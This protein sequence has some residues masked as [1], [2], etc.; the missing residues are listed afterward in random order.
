M[1]RL[2]LNLPAG[3][4]ADNPRIGRQ[5]LMVSGCAVMTL[6]CLGSHATESVEVLL[7]TRLA[8]G[9]G[10]ALAVAGTSAYI[11]D[12]SYTIPAYRARLMGVQTTMVNLGWVVGPPAAG[13]FAAAHGPSVGFLLVSASAATCTVLLATVPPMPPAKPSAAAAGA[14]APS[15]GNGSTAAMYSL[16]RDRQQQGV[17]ALTVGIWVGISAELSVVL[18]HASNAWEMSPAEIGLLLAC[19]S[20]FGMAGG[21][22]G[23]WLADRHGR[24]AV[25]IPGMGGAALAVGGLTVAPTVP[26]F[27]A[28]FSL[29]CISLSVVMPTLQ[30]LAVDITDPAKVGQAQGLHR[31]GADCVFL[32]C[33][34]MLGGMAD[35]QGGGCEL[36]IL[37]TGAG[38]VAAL[39]VFRARAGR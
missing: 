28:L 9:A 25:L 26:A 32:A 35:L 7:A 13:F 4:M 5:P 29:W 2:V 21:P 16:L 8:F 22:L 38:M 34:I 6:A 27:G 37:A 19:G 18:Q 24:R 31:Q 10:S 36:P 1:M 23:G 3:R 11:A 30:A 14:A 33:P 15:A 39:G 12:I 20:T 17:I